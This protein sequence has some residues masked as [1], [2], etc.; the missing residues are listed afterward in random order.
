MH[1]ETRAP[2]STV[3]VEGMSLLR[4]QQMARENVLRDRC[5]PGGWLG[6]HSFF[7]PVAMPSEGIANVSREVVALFRVLFASN[8]KVYRETGGNLRTKKSSQRMVTSPRFER[9]AQTHLPGR[10]NFISPS[11]PKYLYTVRG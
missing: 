10:Q 11:F 4:K 6:P 8:R 5:G 2:R 3:K 7:S 9:S 1:A